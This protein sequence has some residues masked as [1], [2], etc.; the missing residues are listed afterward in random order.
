[1]CFHSLE[2]IFR[3]LG[4]I[5]LLL[6]MEKYTLWYFGESSEKLRIVCFCSSWWNRDTRGCSWSPWSSLPFYGYRRKAEISYGGGFNRWCFD[7]TSWVGTFCRCS[8]KNYEDCIHLISQNGK[9]NFYIFWSSVALLLMLW[10][11][12]VLLCTSQQLNTGKLCTMQMQ[13]FQLPCRICT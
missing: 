7:S 10:T 5:L 6:G 8:L 12:L 3:Q 9:V 1:M 13:G 11:L 2:V 4:K